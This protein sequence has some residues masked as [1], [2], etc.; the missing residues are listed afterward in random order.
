VKGVKRKKKKKKKKKMKKK[1]KKKDCSLM[2][3][4]TEEDTGS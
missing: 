4:E 3:G 1:K 2:F